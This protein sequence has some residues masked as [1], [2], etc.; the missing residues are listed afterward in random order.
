MERPGLMTKHDKRMWDLRHKPWA[1]EYKMDLPA[2][3]PEMRVH[4]GEEARI[5]MYL[6]ALL[7]SIIDLPD[8]SLG[9]YDGGREI[10]TPQS[11]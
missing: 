3:L 1:Y 2:A 10:E 8:I 7:A 5:G 6:L 11:T 4:D 9:A